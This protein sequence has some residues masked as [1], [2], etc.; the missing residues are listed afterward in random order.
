MEQTSVPQVITVG[1]RMMRLAIFGLSLMAAQMIFMIYLQ[2][3]GQAEKAMIVNLS[4]K[5]LIPIPLLFVMNFF[6]AVRLKA[7]KK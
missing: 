3:T 5:C 6:T 7:D 4:R 1:T 2:S